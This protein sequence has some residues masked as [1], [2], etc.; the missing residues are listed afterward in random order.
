M[1]KVAAILRADNGGLGTLSSLFHAG[2]GFHRT[3]SLSLIEAESRPDRFGAHNRHTTE[4]DFPAELVQWVCEGADVLLSFETWYRNSVPAMARELG[5]KTALMPMVECCQR[6]GFGL[7]DTD[8]AICPHALCLDEMRGNTPGLR[9]AIKTLLSPPCDVERIKFTPRRTAQA[10]VHHAGHAGSS[11]RNNTSKVIA[12]WKHVR[13]P[14]RLILRSQ[15]EIP[16]VPG[17][18]RISVIRG[19]AENYWDLWNEGLGDV[20]LHPH[21]WEGCGLPIYEALAAGMP[22]MT[23]RWWPFCDE[24]DRAGWLP[25]SS[26]ALS[27]D[28][29]SRVRK[30]ILRDIASHETTPWFIAEAVDRAYG[31]DLTG[32]SDESRAWAE[33]HS[34]RTQRAV[35]QRLFGDLKAGR[36]IAEIFG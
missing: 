3:I 2:M 12:A 33:A 31:T 25:P 9:G 34:W 27:I 8:L 26:Q 28:V 21:R 10:F 1:A 6:D 24:G 11:D 35:W 29:T 36:K 23:T 14:A 5:V 20:Y 13:S 17:D 4:R 18:I 19:A 15:G 7:P 32:A 30:T 16:D 22:V